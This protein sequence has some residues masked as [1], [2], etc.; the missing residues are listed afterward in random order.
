MTDTETLQTR[1]IDIEDLSFDRGAH[2][3]VNR[4][5][6]AIAVGERLGVRGRAPELAVHLRSWCR[7]RG[8]DLSW[9]DSPDKSD[10]AA[11]DTEGGS[12]PLIAWVT[13][14]GFEVG[15]WRG[16]EQAGLPDASI[17]GA[18]VERPAASWGLAARGATVE[19]GAPPFHFGITDKTEIW[20]ENIPRLYAQAV[21]AQ[22]DPATAI[23][24]DAA[25]DLPVDVES[26]V[27][28]VM[29]YLIENECRRS[30]W[31]K[32]TRISARRCNY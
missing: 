8:H 30:F 19:A 21:A 14:G 6:Q 11:A 32:F 31:R 3:L 17:E 26:A 12:S 10:T 20:A 15:R 23:D 29:T 18:V 9:P 24:W 25:F 2:L 22:W 13:R 27:V 5:L 28:Q 4:A 16:A 7:A 1:T